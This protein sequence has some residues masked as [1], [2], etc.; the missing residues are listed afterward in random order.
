MRKQR[1]SGLDPSNDW[2][3][4]VDDRVVDHGLNPLYGIADVVLTTREQK[5]HADTHHWRNRLWV[6]NRG[7]NLLS[8]LQVL[9]SLV[10]FTLRHMLDGEGGLVVLPVDA[11]NGTCSYLTD[12]LRSVLPAAK[13]L[14]YLG[15]LQA[16]PVH[17]RATDAL[18]GRVVQRSEE[19]L[20]CLLKVVQRDVQA[21][22]QVVVPPQR[23]RRG[24]N[25]I[26]HID[27]LAQQGQSFFSTD[28]RQRASQ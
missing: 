13:P 26:R 7:G 10:V 24:I 11:E 1:S 14:H 20:H 4:V 23:F 6:T 9:L 22:D 3:D 28:Q 17:D 27:R 2:H 15:A 18:A 8:P 12:D 5:P 25:A 16:Y 19:D 21:R